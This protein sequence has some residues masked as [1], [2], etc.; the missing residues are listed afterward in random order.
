[1]SHKG[2]AQGVLLA[3][4][5]PLPFELRVGYKALLSPR[6]RMMTVPPG[7]IQGARTRDAAEALVDA[8]RA[9]LRRREADVVRLFD[10]DEDSEVAAAARRRPGLFCRDHAPW[11]GPHFGL[12]LPES[13]DAFY[14]RM[15]PK[16]GNPLRKAVRLLD[17]DEPGELSYR[18]FTRPDEVDAFAER[19]ESIA[20]TLSAALDSFEDTPRRAVARILAGARLWRVRPQHQAA[21]VRLLAWM[22]PMAMS[23]TS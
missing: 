16:H 17:Q 19:A 4:C 21:A 3:V 12:V 6:V 22:A 8:L 14:S 9:L 2:Q 18:V 1:M 10:I 11:F 23:F 5:H 13:T 7:G 20:R 15:K